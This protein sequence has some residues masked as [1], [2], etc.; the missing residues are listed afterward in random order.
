MAQRQYVQPPVLPKPRT[1][2]KPAIA[3][4]PSHLRKEASFEQKNEKIRPTLAKQPSLNHMTPKLWVKTQVA[5]EH[6]HKTVHTD[7]QH[8]RNIPPSPFGSNKWRPAPQLHMKQNIGAESGHKTPPKAD[9]S[10][11]KK[12]RPKEL[13]VCVINSEALQEED[14]E[15]EVPESQP[16]KQRLRPTMSGPRTPIPYRYL[17]LVCLYK[18]LIV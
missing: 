9:L 14:E 18:L 15:K 7:T 11:E 17:C 6:E 12:E 3:A 16:T 1:A 10:D 2:S 4:K 13:L 8:H 5:S